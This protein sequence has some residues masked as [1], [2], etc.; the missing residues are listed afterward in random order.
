MEL[1]VL[2]KIFEALSDPTRFRILNLLQEGELCVCDIMSVLKEPQS[3]VSRHLAYLRK[4]NLAQ[5]RKE[6][7]WMYYRLNPPK[8]KT[9]KAIFSALKQARSDFKALEKDR[10]TFY[11]NKNG[12][13]ACC[14]E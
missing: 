11:K 8:V 13:V 12:L 7:L 9:F 2:Q 5:A 4:S 1:T 6:G 14:A 3:K 10:R